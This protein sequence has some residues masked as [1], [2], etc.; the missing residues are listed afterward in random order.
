MEFRIIRTQSGDWKRV[1]A[2]RLRALADAPDAFASTLAE[3]RRLTDEAWRARAENDQSVQFLAV[4]PENADLGIAAGAPYVGEEKTAGLFGM[5]V[6]PD[7]RRL[8]IGAAL[9]EAVVAWAENEDYRRVV[10]DVGSANEAALALY[11]TCGFAPN[12]KTGRLPA[13]RVH[14][15]EHQMERILH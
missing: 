3:E 1:R 14:I 10:L 13:S 5:W 9:V 4:A 7:A 8:G 15:A 12:G 11:R 2:V 6:A